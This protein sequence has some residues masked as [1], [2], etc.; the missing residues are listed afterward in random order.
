[1]RGTIA[2]P[3]RASL[4]AADPSDLVRGS[5]LTPAIAQALSDELALCRTCGACCSFSR[6]WP[7]FTTEDD[8]DLDRIPRE[9][10]DH[11]RGR[12]RC[13]GDRCAALEGEVGVR[14]SCAVYSVRPDVCRTCEPGDDACNLARHRFGL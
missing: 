13:S 11:R 7:R 12:M 1:V 8:V 2:R 6:E 5:D 10:V 9:L 3:A 14:T 4:D